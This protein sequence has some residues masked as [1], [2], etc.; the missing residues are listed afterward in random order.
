MAQVA[1]LVEALKSALK[2]SRMTYANVAAGL[3]LSES[4]VKRKFS[5]HEFSLSEIDRI[6]TLCSMDISDLVKLMEQQHGRLHALTVDQER[7]IAADIGLLVVTVC[8]LNRWSFD[9][10]IEFYVFEELELVQMLARLD[11]LRLIE[12]QPNNRIKLLVAPNFG[13]LPNGPIEQVF[14]KV[15]QQDFFAVRFGQEDHELIVLNGMLAP[16]SNAEFRKKMERLAREFELLNQEDTGE[17][18]E[19]RRGYTVVLALRDW[20]YQGFADLLR[21]GKD[22]VRD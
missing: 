6:C 18:F 8:V 10:I 4:S 17:T 15:I 11:R 19:T 14:L 22:S 12:L 7:E 3:G 20:R 1:A 16:A 21:D 5:R 9:N 13:W 2:S